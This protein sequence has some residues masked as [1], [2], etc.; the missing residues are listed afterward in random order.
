MEALAAA[1]V[2]SIATLGPASA[3]GVIVM[4]SVESV[5]RQPESEGSVRGLMILGVAF[6]EALAIL[7]FVLFFVVLFA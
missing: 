3:I 7:G 1:L 6:V 5:A 4:K 2:Y